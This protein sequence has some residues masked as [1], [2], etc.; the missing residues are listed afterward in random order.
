[1]PNDMQLLELWAAP[2]LG[3]LQPAARSAMARQLARDLRRSQAQR[4]ASQQSPSGAPFAPRRR[5]AEPLRG[6]RGKVRRKKDAMFAKLR[7]SRWLKAKGD[8]N[9]AEV[10]F[11]GRVARLARVHQEGLR[12][13]VDRNGPVVT[14]PR[15]ELIGFSPADVQMIRERLFT[16]IGQSV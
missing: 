2:L 13:R 16:L 3:R 11:F 5:R 10:G 7:T 6:K 9:V 4:I 8:G 14:Y 15:R 1:M 12:D